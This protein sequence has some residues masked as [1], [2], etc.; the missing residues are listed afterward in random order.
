LL[1]CE[2]A[3]QNLNPGAVFVI[4]D[5]RYHQII[6]R[7]W[8]AFDVC[9]RTASVFGSLIVPPSSVLMMIGGE[10]GL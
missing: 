2:G 8:M 1:H 5:I 4:T 10:C 7:N 9:V 3:K 6:S